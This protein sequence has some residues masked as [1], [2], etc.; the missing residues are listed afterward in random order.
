MTYRPD[1]SP[2]SSFEEVL[3]PK[4][5]QALTLNKPIIILGVLN[6][7]GLEKS[8]P[9]FKALEKFC[10][11]MNLKQLISTPTR[12]TPYTQTLL[13]V[14]M[15]CSNFSVRNRGVIQ[16]PISD[17]SIVFTNLK[18]KKQKTIPQYVTT[19]SYKHYNGKQFACDLAKEAG[20]LLTTFDKPDVNSKLKNVI[21]TL[22]RILDSHALQKQ[23]K[24]CGRPCP[25]VHKEVKD[26]MKFRDILLK[27]FVRTHDDT[28]WCNFESRDHVKKM[29]RD[30]ENNYTFNDVQ[31]NKNSPR[32]LWKMINRAVPSK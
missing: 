7:N 29:L 16:R 4:Y 6:C 27:T 22:M 21:N 28:D 8:C 25:F 13:N 24:I 32:A 19:R 23:I 11:D 30:A 20:A 5:I 31:A 15:I 1:D 18:I 3:K 10:S 12:I 9:K 26:M 14:I 2:L 17:H